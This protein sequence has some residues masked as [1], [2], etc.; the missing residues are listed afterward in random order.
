MAA[1]QRD[2]QQNRERKQM[3]KVEKDG[4]KTDFISAAILPSSP[5]RQ[6]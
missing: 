1:S 2:G 5:S 6:R 4:G 3:K